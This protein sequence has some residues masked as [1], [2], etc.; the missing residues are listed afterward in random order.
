PQARQAMKEWGAQFDMGAE[1]TAE[2]ILRVIT[3]TMARGIRKVSVE[4]GIDVRSCDLMSFGGAGPLHAA[5]LARELGM[6]SA[7]IP[8]SPG[9]ASAVG[10][11]D[12]PVRQDFSMPTFVAEDTG[13]YREIERALNQLID[14][15]AESMPEGDTRFEN[16]VDA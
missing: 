6:K 12:A 9:I 3:A 1:E 5:D 11:L 10:M 16:F 8:P 4:R 15:A 14:Q 2:G 13:D 7:I